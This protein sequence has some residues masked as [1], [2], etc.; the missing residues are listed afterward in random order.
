LF[1]NFWFSY[2]KNIIFTLSFFFYLD[3]FLRNI[4]ITF[5]ANILLRLPPS[6]IHL[7]TPVVHQSIQ[8][9]FRIP[10]RQKYALCGPEQEFVVLAP[11][12]SGIIIQKEGKV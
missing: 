5:S 1:F 12:I 4:N 3:K 6:K 10:E 8:P 11:V 7:Q 2:L 9:F